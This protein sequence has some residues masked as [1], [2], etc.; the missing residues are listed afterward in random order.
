MNVQY[1]TAFV[2]LHELREALASQIPTELSGS[3]EID[4]DYFAATSS[5]GITKKT[6]AIG[7]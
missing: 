5:P 6:V 2:L 1:K 4:G 7:A 3:V